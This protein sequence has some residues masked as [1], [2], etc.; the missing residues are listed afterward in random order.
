LFHLPARLY[1]Q[2]VH[3]ANEQGKGLP[4]FASMLLN[5]IAIGDLYKAVLDD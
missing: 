3:A 4:I 1:A 5:A 2:L